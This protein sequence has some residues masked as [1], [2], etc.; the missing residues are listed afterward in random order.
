MKTTALGIENLCFPCHSHCRYCL[1]E[2]CAKATGTDYQR[3]KLFARRVYEEAGVKAPDLRVYYYIGYCMDDENLSDYIG[4]SR[5]TGAPSGRFLQLN[6][7]R[8]RNSAETGEMIR[9]LVSDGIRLIDLTF[10]GSREY[11]D[12]FAGRTGDFDYL[13]SILDA[14]N[15]HGLEVHISVPLYRENFLQTNELQEALARSHHGEISFFLPHA[16][17]RGKL[18]DA[19]RLTSDDLPELSDRVK[20]QLGSYLTEGEWLKPKLQGPSE[21]R[22]LTLSL[23]P[24]NIAQLESMSLEE[25]MDELERLDDR[26]YA[27]IPPVEELAARYG[28]PSGKRLYRRFRDL[29]LE[30]QQRYLAESGIDVWDMNDETHHFSV[31]I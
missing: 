19:L 30:W 22:V 17:G 8:L 10:Y 15:R 20:R 11:H 23:K 21:S 26:Y 28:D 5:E 18:L 4:F 13:L 1:L 27:A 24:E 14:A 25:I 6:G 9:Q 29:Y 3:G 12:R 16:K 7:L 31:R 2:S